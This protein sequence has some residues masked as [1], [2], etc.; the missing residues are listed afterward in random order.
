MVEELE[1]LALRNVPLAPGI[2][3][4]RALAALAGAPD[5]VPFV[6]QPLQPVLAALKSAPPGEVSDEVRRVWA[7][8]ERMVQLRPRLGTLN[9]ESI[10]LA[11]DALSLEQESA[12]E[13]KLVLTTR[14]APLAGSQLGN[15]GGFLDRPL[16]EADYYIGVYDGLHQ[17]AVHWCD[18]Q[19]PYETSRFAPVRKQDGTGDLDFH[20]LDTQRCMGEAM[21]I[22]AHWLRLFDSSKANAVVKVLARR[23]LAAWLGSNTEGERVASL[24]EWQWLGSAPPELKS[25]GSVGKVVQVLSSKES[26]AR[27]EPKRTCA[28]AS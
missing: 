13:R 28:T 20:Q 7:R 21:G 2:E 17:A 4:S 11:Q 19:D 5:S 15:F 24:P 23:E 12:G 6:V 9:A 16:R 8:L 25:V 22:A 14:F 18:N 1:A 27:R 3:A 26:P 10:Q